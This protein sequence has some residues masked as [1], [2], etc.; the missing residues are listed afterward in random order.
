M[1]SAWKIWRHPYKT[2]RELCRLEREIVSLKADKDELL[3]TG[4][5][6]KAEN[7]DL[8]LAL[9]ELENSRKKLNK[10]NDI[11][12]EENRSFRIKLQEYSDT[13]RRIAA[14]EDLL[15][16]AEEIKDRYEKRIEKL[17]RKISAMNRI[18]GPRET[19]HDELLEIDMSGSFN[20][21]E[22]PGEH[23]AGVTDRDGNWLEE[24]PE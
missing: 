22:G 7:D 1:F 24:L 12:E 3:Q 2:A 17:R 18:S 11:L 10:E 14:I 5:V 15:S 19:S 23:G 21:G 13:D 9:A 4:K 8:A 20:V 16:K 6:L